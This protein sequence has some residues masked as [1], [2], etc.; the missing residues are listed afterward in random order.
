MTSLLPPDGIAADTA[1]FLDFDGTL[2]PIQDD[3]E[4]VA[5]P[6]NGPDILAALSNQLS[7]ALMLISGRDIR[8]LSRRVPLSLWRAGGHGLDVCAPGE[9][10][11]EQVATPDH[12]TATMEE[13]T[14]GLEGVRIEAKGP[15]IAVHYRAAPHNGERL[16]E[17]LARA[18]E[19][20]EGYRLQH[21]KMVF[22]VKPDGAHKGRALA[23]MMQGAPFAGR[24]PLMV[25]DDTTDEDAMAVA[26]ELG[27][28]AV[29]VGAADTLAT[30]RLS[31]PATVW[32]WLETS[33]R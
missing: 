32:A 30:H 13:A 17:R 20:L 15:V 5:L 25:G 21:G 9:Q 18:E 23:R 8:D 24:V 22:E 14:A 31:D 29:K 1:L 28:L 16:A 10:P 11:G 4:T 26:I 6:E 7:G 19:T 2:A 3:P 12:V 27:G 33:I